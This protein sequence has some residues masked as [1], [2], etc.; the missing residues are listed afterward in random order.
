MMSSK[1]QI[2]L[3]TLRQILETNGY[4]NDRTLTN[5]TFELIKQHKIFENAENLQM[6]T[7]YERTLCLTI[8]QI[9][10]ALSKMILKHKKAQ[11]DLSKE[12]YFLE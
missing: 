3:N 6:Q 7:G 4:L 1:S 12:M 10:F 11:T 9:V 8:I 2:S 5:L